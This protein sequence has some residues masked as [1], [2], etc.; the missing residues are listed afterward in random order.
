MK[1]PRFRILGALEVW[2]GGRRVLIG[3]RQ[4]PAVLATLL[5]HANRVVSVD[6]LADSLWGDEPP[7]AARRLVHGCVAELRRTLRAEAGGGEPPV[8]TRPPGYLVEV[9][10][11]ELDLDVFAELV[12]AARETLRQPSAAALEEAGGMLRDAL[13]LW[14]GPAL[15]GVALHGFEGALAALE[16]RR[17][18]ALEERVDVDLRL[19]RHAALVGELQA[20]VQAHPA[21]ER[22]WAQLMLALARS[23]RQ[24]DALA[25]YQQVR[26]VLVD[27]LG[28]EPG[29][30]LRTLHQAVLNGDDPVEAYLPAQPGTD[31]D[32]TRM[33]DAPLA[34][35][36]P[37]PE[38]QPRPPR[39]LP[40]GVWGFTGRPAELATLDAALPAA[41]GPDATGRA[42]PA[43]HAVSG[44]PGVGKTALA[45]HWAHRVADRFP[46]GQLYVNLRG[47]D[48][49]SRAMD[50]DEAVR[51]F[52][53][54]LG[55]PPDRVPAGLDAQ[56]ALYRST[57]AGR[58]VLVLLDNA[59]DA[60]QV[61]PLLPGTPTAL[62]VVTSRDQLTAL[63]AADG[64]VPI[65][66]GL[67]TAAEARELLARRLGPDRIAAHPAAADA[68][69]DSCA[70]LPLALT[71]AA[72]RAAVRPGLPLTALAAELAE[73]RGRLDVLTAHDPAADVRAVFSWSYQ[74]LTPAA[75]RLFRLLGLHPGVDTSEAAAA[76]LAGHTPAE[77]R[78]LLAELARAS[79]LAEHAAARYTFHD[80][81]RAYATELAR[82]TDP[83]GERAAAVDRL[84]D[85]YVHTGH[86]AEQLLNGHRDPPVLPL[87]PPAP[88]AHPE[89]LTGHQQA[90]DWLAAER[91]V[92]LA[93]LRLAAET[94]HD[95]E[96]WQL[97]WALDTF[98]DRRGYWHDLATAWQAALAAADRL[99]DP[100]AQAYALRLLA[101]ADTFVGRTAA[102]QAH[103]ERALDLY[104]QAGDLAGQTHAHL[105]LSVLWERQG[106]LD[107]ALVHDRHALELSRAAGHRRG[108][109]QALNAYGWDHAQLG[110]YAA[111]LVHC[112]EALA[113]HQQEGHRLGEANTWDSL[114]YAHRH[115]GQYAEAIEAYQ[116]AIDG[117][118]DL[119]DRYNEADTLVNL[120]DVHQA[121]GDPDAA[122]ATWTR[123]LR[124][125]IELDHADA[126]AVRAKL[127]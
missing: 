31:G 14:R 116:H 89:R 72:A 92:L 1:A 19:G 69:L 42:A 33:E 64:A 50:P 49:G 60:E 36:Q 11:G 75:A 57:L 8:L 21:R 5:L 111:A 29:A 38:P 76:S 110:D 26:T 44:P 127:R 113:L 58:R 80:L 46:D 65:T 109:A 85:H 23:H 108:L 121:A 43:V 117:F 52:L 94:G 88:G 122:R 96:V 6:R 100:N 105:N 35:A 55:V 61:R 86:T 120:G 118:R 115:L 84:L 54:A 48:Q 101:W 68:I 9:R 66:L 102:A 32:A 16:E 10:P 91:P 103:L 18:A 71:I 81:L 28:I 123:A 78:P 4:Q 41:T 95:T 74:A 107:Q 63:V 62:A 83:D 114:G 124:I 59:R 39:Q 79:L 53:G 125:L 90:M 25:A 24:A 97:A 15:D 104:A 93:A 12:G 67:L 119:G 47:Y 73:A 99:A 126:E 56:A 13:A 20:Q 77:A 37:R 30:A 17:L 106:R 82:G 112:R 40:L 98:L 87:R 51:G 27:Q 2:Q 45:V 7:A 70:R 34:A 3:G 22:A